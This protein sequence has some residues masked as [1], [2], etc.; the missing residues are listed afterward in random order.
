MAPNRSDSFAGWWLGGFGC[1]G[2]VT[3]GVLVAVFANLGFV[4][5]AG[6]VALGAIMGVVVGLRVAVALVLLADE[7]G[8]DEEPP[9]SRLGRIYLRLDQ[10]ID[11]TGL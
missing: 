2:A 1:A 3:A 6:I 10:F 7:L 11:R 4:G 8:W 5:S 9:S